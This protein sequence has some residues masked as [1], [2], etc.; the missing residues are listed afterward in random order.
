[1]LG[2]S[3]FFLNLRNIRIRS[4]LCFYFLSLLSHVPWRCQQLEWNMF[5]FMFSFY[6][7]YLFSSNIS[8]ILFPCCEKRLRVVAEWLFLDRGCW[9]ATIQLLFIPRLS[10][11]GVFGS[12][13]LKLGFWKADMWL[14]VSLPICKELPWRESSSALE[15]LIGFRHLL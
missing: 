1:M 8:L 2:N 7:Q 13:I 3:N 5:A 10:Y 4:T 15:L 9:K 14:T 6:L 12:N 11:C